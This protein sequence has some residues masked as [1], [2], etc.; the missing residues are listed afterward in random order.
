MR[1]LLTM[2]ESLS[3]KKQLKINETIHSKN[4]LL[5][6]NSIKTN[7]LIKAAALKSFYLNLNNK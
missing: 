6:I 5:P 4:Q 3:Q 2:K 7:F 1:H